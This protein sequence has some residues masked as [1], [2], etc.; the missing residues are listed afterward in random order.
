MEVRCRAC[1]GLFSITVST[2]CPTKFA[3]QSI[4]KQYLGPSIIFKSRMIEELDTE[5][6]S[7]LGFDDALPSS[8]QVYH[9]LQCSPPAGAGRLE[10]L[11]NGPKYP[12]MG[13]VGLLYQES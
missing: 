3:F 10:L 12:D 1:S 8:V 13:N 11:S 9:E 5:K 6:C 4:L 7:T 2:S